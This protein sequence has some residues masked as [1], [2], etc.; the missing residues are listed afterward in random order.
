M[1]TSYWKQEGMRS[2]EKGDQERSSGWTIKN[3]I[4]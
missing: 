1:G 2:C 3:K 4:K